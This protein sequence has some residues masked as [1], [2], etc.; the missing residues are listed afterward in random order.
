MEGHV[1]IGKPQTLKSLER[2][3]CGV[4]SDSARNP[5]WFPP[6]NFYR[7]DSLAEVCA[8]PITF[9]VDCPALS[10]SLPQPQPQVP[11][12]ALCSLSSGKLM[13]PIQQFALEEGADERRAGR[14]I[15]LQGA[16]A[17]THCVVTACSS[18]HSRGGHRG[19][20]VTL[21]RTRR[22]WM[23]FLSKITTTTVWVQEGGHGD[24][25]QLMLAR[26]CCLF[27]YYYYETMPVPSTVN[28]IFV[29]IL[30][31]LFVPLRMRQGRPLNQ[32][33]DQTW[34]AMIGIEDTAST[35]EG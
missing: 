5:H 28:Y 21:S 35:V 32:M 12:S 11:Y 22:R 13:L 33:F 26:F 4:S 20:T 29:Y 16:G 3:P 9:S 19:Q 18:G 27:I 24:P 10:R 7:A 8:L 34:V 17:H 15:R 30:K 14:L 25:V 31:D 23:C 6:S 2:G 1:I